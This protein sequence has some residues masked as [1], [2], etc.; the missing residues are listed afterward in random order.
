MSISG[1]PAG[2]NDLLLKLNIA[3][4]IPSP[5]SLL[6]NQFASIPFIDPLEE[7]SR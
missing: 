6:C 1:L 7:V 3:T 4:G 5:L 2:S